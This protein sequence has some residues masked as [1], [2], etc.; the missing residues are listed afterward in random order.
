MAAIIA[1]AL[2]AMSEDSRAR[3]PRIGKGN[4]DVLQFGSFRLLAHGDR[5]NGSLHSRGQMSLWRK[6]E[7]DVPVAG[8]RLG[9][10]RDSLADVHRLHR[11]E[12]GAVARKARRE[13]R[14]ANE[15]AALVL[16]AP[17]ATWEEMKAR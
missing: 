16:V 2:A 1:W 17:A 9:N 12:R 10:A 11:L 13:D 4:S 15:T 14:G 3:N 8:T 7:A 6:S 5:R